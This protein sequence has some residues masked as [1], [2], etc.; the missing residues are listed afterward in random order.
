M[1]RRSRVHTKRWDRCVRDI[2]RKGGASSA[3]AV[4]SSR[5][6]ERGSVLKSHRRKNRKPRRARGRTV[7]TATSRINP[8]AGGQWVILA[9]KPGKPTHVYHGDRFVS[10]RTARLTG[11]GSVH[12]P[13]APL[14]AMFARHLKRM[15]PRSLKGWRLRVTQLH[16]QRYPHADL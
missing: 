14:A 10:E 11:R 2:R 8:R 9:R 6:G 7:T 5:L 16:P 13:T 12:F 15:F 1:P 3:E 4:C